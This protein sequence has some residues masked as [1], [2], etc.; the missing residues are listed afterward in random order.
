MGSVLNR[1]KKGNEIFLQAGMTVVTVN[2]SPIS[3][4]IF[5]EL[6]CVHHQ[7]TT[8]MKW[9]GAGRRNNVG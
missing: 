4:W 3:R 2:G 9:M 1:L 7:D 6:Y 8:E 5:F